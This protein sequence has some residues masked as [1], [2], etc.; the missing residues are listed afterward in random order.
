LLLSLTI[1]LNFAYGACSLPE[2]LTATECQYI[3]N[4][5]YLLE[6]AMVVKATNV[7][8]IFADDL[9]AWAL[10]AAG[11][12][13]II[14]PAL[15]GLAA[16]GVRFENFFC[17]SPVCSPARA[18]LLT[19]TIPSQNGIHDWIR[20]G[21]AGS[22]RID[23]LQGRTTIPDVLHH[24]GYRCAMVGKWHLGASDSPRAPYD[25]WFAHE[26][27]GGSYYDAPMFRGSEREEVSGYITDAIADDAIEYLHN[28]NDRDQPFYLNVS[29]TAP[30][31][32]WVDAH[33]QDLLDLYSET[34]FDS[35]PNEAPHPWLFMENPEVAAA[36][37]DP[38]GSLRGYFA[39]VTGLDRAIGRI[40]ATLK[41]CGFTSD[42]L[43][44]FIGDNGFNAG[45]HGVWGKGNGTYPQNM[46]D[47][48]VKVPAIFA[49]P[50][51][52]EP[53]RV[54]SSLVS[55]YDLMPTLLDYLG[56]DPATPSTVP[57]RS[58][59]AALEGRVSE[60]QRHVVVYDEYGPVRMI[61]GERWKYVHRSPNGP[62]ELYDLLTDPDERTN[63]AET[64][65]YAE[66]IE[67]LRER[68][69]RW[70][71]DHAAPELDGQDLPVTGLGQVDLVGRTAAF[72][73][74]AGN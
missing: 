29:F 58:F 4:A 74:L 70:F 18:S 3:I 41:E 65:E 66:I 61:R 27:G 33:P 72:Q 25:H 35:V 68:L 6:A 62:H 67:E 59:R 15:D 40:L 21:N 1:S 39:A 30:H 44:A 22:G 45:H 53:G 16:K 34:E 52:I 54:E 19:G 28:S 47:S 69:R 14:T 5:H 64:T 24:H 49:Q 73:P 13:E 10:G 46:F 43:V 71:A 48:S 36:T 9:G 11:N 2:N 7:L 32:P 51:R 55:G 63:R 31:H 57:G 38:I 42:T 20:E 17:T 8:L 26:G 60:S 50:D 37:A 12:A 23:F 56:I